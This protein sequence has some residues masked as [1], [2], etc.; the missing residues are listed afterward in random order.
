V[1]Q[2]CQSLYTNGDQRR[3]MGRE[4]RE[5]VYV[6]YVSTLSANVSGKDKDI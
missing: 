2:N 5:G 4:A 1:F 3:T 6:F